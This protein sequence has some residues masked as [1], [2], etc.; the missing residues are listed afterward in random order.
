M[1]W[2]RASEHCYS[3]AY[4]T[5]TKHLR[6]SVRRLLQIG[7]CFGQSLA[8]WADWFPSA[9]IIGLD[10]FT[11]RFING[12]RSLLR[13]RGMAEDRVAVMRGNSSDRT[14]L[15]T[16]LTRFGPQG[17]DLVVDDGS[18]IYEDM[19]YTYQAL[20]IAAL[21]PGGLYVIEDTMSSWKS[22]KLAFFIQK[23]L[24]SSQWMGRKLKSH[25]LDKSLEVQPD[26]YAAWVEAIEFRRGLVIIRKRHAYSMPS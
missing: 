7:I 24:E 19:I 22:H 10:V 3:P 11:D 20:F 4:E 12:S 23:L 9:E 1:A 6:H 15:S 26:P 14:F 21:K 17:F 13:S 8:F 25:E 5:L 16:V 18:H 2:T